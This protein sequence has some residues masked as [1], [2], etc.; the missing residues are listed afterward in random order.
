MET[1]KQPAKVQTRSDY[2]TRETILNL[3]SD[4]ENATLSSVEGTPQ[5]VEG[6]AY[7][8]LEHLDRGGPRANP[9]A[10]L[11]GDLLPQLA[12]RE[13]T[14]TAILATLAGFPAVAPPPTPVVS[15]EDEITL[16]PGTSRTPGLNPQHV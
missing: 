9:S 8:A 16:P 7:L 15:P 12:V 6:E 1:Q 2:V 3:L 10:G 11:P 5:L 4:E 14:W 13:T